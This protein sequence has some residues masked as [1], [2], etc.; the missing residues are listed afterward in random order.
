MSA[1]TVIIV[2]LFAI[3]IALIGIIAYCIWMNENHRDTIIPQSRN[4]ESQTIE[5]SKHFKVVNHK[6]C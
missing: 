5:L 1:S 4:V 2:Y 6:F 3:V